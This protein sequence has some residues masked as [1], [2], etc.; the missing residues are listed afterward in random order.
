M[1]V[2]GRLVI[3]SCSESE[4]LGVYRAKGMGRDAEA[5]VACEG[6]QQRAAVGMQSR[7]LV[8]RA[9][10]AALPAGERA[11]VHAAAHVKHRKMRVADAGLCGGGD[12]AL[13]EFRR[14]G[15]GRPVRLVM[16]IVKLADRGEARFKHFHLHL[17]RDGL[18]VVRRQAFDEV[19]HQRA[20]GPE[21]VDLILAAI[22]GEAGHRP[23]EAVGVDIARRGQQRADGNIGVGAALAYARNPAA[24]IDL[25][26]GV[27]PP[28]GR[29]QEVPGE[30]FPV[31]QSLRAFLICAYI[32]S[33]KLHISSGNPRLHAI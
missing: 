22:F 32:L 28:S 24:R 18:D 10:E 1:N 27:P 25:D 6:F 13:A 30:D 5:R 4:S 7:E 31:G 19:I 12:D 8:E 9:A 21:I 14:P 2:H 26:D 17:R 15:V 29:R 33:N 16:E 3:E 20:P 11:P 23:L